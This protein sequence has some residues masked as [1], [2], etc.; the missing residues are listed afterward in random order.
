MSPGFAMT[1]EIE[2][3]QTDYYWN[4][5]TFLCMCLK[6]C[7][8]AVLASQGPVKVMYECRYF[9]CVSIICSYVI[10]VTAYPCHLSADV[11]SEGDL[12]PGWREIADSSEVYFWHVPTG[13]TQY[14][15]PVAS[16]NQETTASNEPDSE[17]DTQKETQDSLKLPNEVRGLLDI[18]HHRGNFI[19][20]VFQLCCENVFALL[21]IF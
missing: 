19:I 18:R 5:S 10:Y 17:H 3:E 12:P 16:G 13:T 14:D 7:I 21:W 11:W 2:Q 6:F 4:A 8:D 15:R 1:T 9:V 20:F